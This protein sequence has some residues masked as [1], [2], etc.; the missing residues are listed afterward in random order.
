MSAGGGSG[1]VGKPPVGLA[2]LLVL[3]ALAA[4]FFVGDVVADFAL[5]GVVFHT[6][7]EAAVAAALVVGVVFGAKEMRR[8][9]DRTRRSEAALSLARGA[10]ADLI[11]KR[12]VAW[13]LTAAE[14]EVALLA[15]KGFDVGEIAGLRGSAPGTV[16]A[17]LS[18]V[19]A[20]SGASGH[21]ELVALFIDDL[22][23]D[24]VARGT[25]AES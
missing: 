3:Q 6:L 24:P 25:S 2:V 17:Q 22:I 5:E 7:L 4:A 12:F 13:N 23:A 8:A 21:A 11:E 9:L 1:G 19:Y 14:R 16:R 15:L 18:R 20:K 10:F